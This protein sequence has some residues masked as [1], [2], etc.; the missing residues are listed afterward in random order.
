MSTHPCPRSDSKEETNSKVLR[1]SG[2]PSGHCCG[3]KPFSMMDFRAVGL[4]DL[5]RLTG[6]S[7][8]QT[9]TADACVHGS[10]QS[11]Q[12]RGFQRGRLSSSVTRLPIVGPAHRLGPREWPGKLV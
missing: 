7:V 6:R 8:R 5:L 10:R 9:V 11:A 2:S 1:A 4:L 3:T 12:R